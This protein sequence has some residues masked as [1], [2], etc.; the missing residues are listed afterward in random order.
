MGDVH[1]NI[2]EGGTG[3]DADDLST[4]S[5]G[6]APFNYITNNFVEPG[7]VIGGI[8]ESPDIIEDF[9]MLKA[10]KNGYESLKQFSKEDK[11]MFEKLV[12]LKKKYRPRPICRSNRNAGEKAKEGFSDLIRV[13]DLRLVELA[14][15]VFYAFFYGLFGFIIGTL[16]NRVFPPLTLE[17]NNFR[18]FVELL[19]QVMLVSIGVFYVKKLIDAVPSPFSRLK[20]YCPYIFTQNVSIVVLGVVIMSTQTSLMNKFEILG[21]RFGT[22]TP[23]P[24]VGRLIV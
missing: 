6:E 19:L 12:E 4:D 13:D 3:V 23:L 10:D 9:I 16:I 8:E 5:R 20:G 18:V 2:P 22:G 17:T 7:D 15:T 11:E 24:F 1:K 21:K 14:E